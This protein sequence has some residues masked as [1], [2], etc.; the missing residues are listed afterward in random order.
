MASA[1]EGHDGRWDASEL[2]RWWDDRGFNDTTA[3]YVLMALSEASQL[4]A[5]DVG[6]TRTARSKQGAT[7]CDMVMKD[8]EVDL[9]ATRGRSAT[10]PSQGTGAP[11]LFS[12]AY[13]HKLFENKR[14]ALKAQ[15]EA[16]QLKEHEFKRN[17]FHQKRMV[18]KRE[19]QRRR[20]IARRDAEEFIQRASERVQRRAS[21]RLEGRHVPSVDPGDAKVA[22]SEHRLPAPKLPALRR[23]KSARRD[24]RG[25]RGRRRQRASYVGR[26]DL[27]VQFRS[28]V[29][30]AFQ[31]LRE[32][33]ES[34][35]SSAESSEQHTS[36]ETGV[37]ET[38]V[39]ETE[40]PL[41]SRPESTRQ[42]AATPPC[43]AVGSQSD[44]AA[45]AEK[46]AEEDLKTGDDSVAS[47]SPISYSEP[48][49][50]SHLRKTGRRY[51][52]EA[53]KIAARVFVMEYL[54]MTQEKNKYVEPHPNPYPNPNSFHGCVGPVPNPYPNRA[55]GTNA[56]SRAG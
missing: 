20:T 1:D 56:R 5:W 46:V 50:I 17:L 36:G 25:E 23:S 55:P 54:M 11:S 42:S 28:R 40:T 2:R 8:W 52:E 14:R 43:S 26:M 29:E 45:A 13:I 32:D 48:S 4:R 18:K 47:K 10:T 30:K 53:K 51:T 19:T 7:I 9:G 12:D 22:T 41:V 6:F 49:N 34:R 33:I 37:Y 27:V 38:K 39:Q 3:D 31:D 15:K 44:L 21:L 35:F 24:G 16:I